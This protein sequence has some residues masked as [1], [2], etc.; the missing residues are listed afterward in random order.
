MNVKLQRILQ[1]SIAALIAF[2]VLF[3]GF[4]LLRTR[5]RLGVT[6]ILDFAVILLLGLIWQAA[7]RNYTLD[8]K[9][10]QKRFVFWAF[11]LVNLRQYL[12]L[13]PKYHLTSV[14][15]DL[16]SLTVVYLVLVSQAKTVLLSASEEKAVF[17]FYLA[18][19]GLLVV[20]GTARWFAESEV[21]HTLYTLTFT[22][23]HLVIVFLLFYWYYQASHTSLD[24]LVR[25]RFRF[26]GVGAAAY[27]TMF[28]FDMVARLVGG[29]DIPKWNVVYLVVQTGLIVIGLGSIYV[30]FSM[31]P[32]LAERLLRCSAQHQSSD[33]YSELLVLAARLSDV[34]AREPENILA[35][36]A[37]AVGTRYGG[38]SDTSL[39]VLRSAANAAYLI[40]QSELPNLQVPWDLSLP[41]EE[42]PLGSSAAAY[43]EQLYHLRSVSRVI[44]VLTQPYEQ[45]KHRKPVE[46]RILHVVIDYLRSDD[47]DVLTKGKGTIYDPTA[48]E[49][50]QQWV[51]E[52]E[53][54]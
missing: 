8:P 21:H 19:A 6:V 28:L 9:A 40:W 27:F 44:Q 10:Q 3:Q 14:L 12:V 7:W 49:A 20:L 16:M 24:P 17:R 41:S 25:W 48:V 26:L 13:A 54:V 4:L 45:L 35:A 52:F 18:S 51:R 30:A 23:G 15:A 39:G 34:L 47:L 22:T 46:A 36:Y 1:G 50:L 53:G 42:V 43:A 11:T 37:V 2:H 32:W 31:S 29:Y 33:I 38:L 5:H